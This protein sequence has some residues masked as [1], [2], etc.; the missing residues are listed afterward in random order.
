MTEIH[1]VSTRSTSGA[2]FDFE[3]QV[4]AWCL[5]RMLGGEVLADHHERCATRLQFQTRDLGWRIDD[6]LA[7]SIANGM[8]GAVAISCKSNV[9]VSSS[10][11]PRGFVAAAWDQWKNAGPFQID[12]DRLL[13]ATRGR[14]AAFHAAWTEVKTA[15]RGADPAMAIARISALRKLRRIFE[16]VKR[17][18]GSG[19]LADDAEVVRLINHLEVRDFDFDLD[20]SQSLLSVL[21]N[22]RLLLRVESPVVARD[23]WTELVDRAKK[24][25]VGSGTIDLYE[26]RGNLAQRFQLRDYPHHAAA[27]NFLRGITKDRLATIRTEFSTG[28]CLARTDQRAKLAEA[29]QSSPITLIHGDSGCGKSGLTKSLLGSRYSASEVVWLTPD[30]LPELLSESGRAKAGFGYPLA[31]VLSSKATPRGVLVLDQAERLRPGD[32]DLLHPVI[33]S[34]S[35]RKDGGVSAWSVVLISQSEALDSGSVRRVA[36]ESVCVLELEGIRK[37]D[38]GAALR[39]T[40]A[41][42]WAALDDDVVSQLR[43]VK[44]L[45]WLIEAES[46]FQSGGVSSFSRGAIAD[47][48]WKYWTDDRAGLQRLLM[49]LA[50]REAIQFKR[51]VGLSDLE[52]AELQDFETRPPAFP[53]NST[54]RNR[55]EFEHDLAAEWSRY[56]KLKEIAHEVEAWAELAS[57]PMWIG[58][59]RMLGQ[60]LVRQRKGETTEWDVAF[61]ALEAADKTPA[62]DILLES[63]AL[64]PSAE[65]L[66]T[67]RVDLLLSGEGARLNRLL[68]RFHHVA[69]LP[70]WSH[71]EVDASLTLFLEARYRVPIIPRWPGLVQFLAEHRSQVAHLMSPAVAE[72][73]NTWLSSLPA[74]MSSGVPT[75]FRRELA[76][77]GLDTA[78][79][80]QIAQGKGVIFADGS[81]QPIYVAA[82]AGAPDLPDEVSA[83]ALEMSQRRPWQADIQARIN[84]HYRLAHEEHERR[85]A[86]DPEYRERHE[87]RANA[88]FSLSSARKLPPWPIGPKRRIE[89]H[90]REACI[91]TNALQPLMRRCPEVALEVLLATLIEDSPEEDLSRSPSVRDDYGLQFEQHGHPTIFWKSPFYPFLQISPAVALGGLI[92]LIDFCT[93]RWAK[94][95]RRGGR[96]LTLTLEAGQTRKY[97]GSVR[98]LDWVHTSEFGPGQLFCALA[99]L[100]KWLGTLAEQGADITPYLIRILTNT[101]SVALIGAL[102]NIGKLKPKLFEASLLPLLT[103]H[104]LYFWDEHRLEHGYIS[105]FDAFSWARQGELAFNAAQQWYSAPHRRKTLRGLAVSLASASPEVAQTIRTASRKWRTVG[106]KKAQLELRML[107]AYLDPVNWRSEQGADGRTRRVL[108]YPAKL[109]REIDAFNRNVEPMRRELLIPFQCQEVL[110]KGRLLTAEECVVL[111]SL[112]ITPLSP[113]AEAAEGVESDSADAR[114]AAACTLLALGGKWLED[115]GSTLSAAQTVLSEHI[116]TIGDTSQ[117]LRDLNGRFDRGTSELAAYAVV[118]LASRRVEGRKNPA[119]SSCV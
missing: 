48:L 33:Q 23:L 99:A 103:S 80:L 54:R 45:A 47:R 96:H 119:R 55:I 102:L 98:L 38:V 15:C 43:N 59:I 106:N 42:G 71:G 108:T 105:Q 118:A 76:E 57:N 70:G 112:V 79:Q 5:V 116:E 19:D 11:L 26:L 1:P 36:G 114:I 51:S 49:R 111:E 18:E 37:G 8:E 82:L 113:K 24:A 12:R 95:D 58:P 85:L 30:E 107:R 35:E 109:Q 91:Q 86:A 21:S 41:L 50:E 100:E 4:A 84:E 28:Y 93:E 92:T 7:S 117:V 29:I 60:F 9:Q 52:P 61:A 69:T 83:W 87:R 77:V 110:R 78:R 65:Q 10:G 81:E 20:G 39:S 17:P 64:D 115:H 101:K 2:G 73:C 94:E 32:A 97:V 56:Q 25:R 72:V 74:Q 66:L 62:A 44:T 16:S 14:H 88:A 53:L 6:L 31:E 46:Q 27:W 90:F 63:L 104:E 22:C 75:P 13:L 67:A 89:G 34:I 68:H 3:D 40:S